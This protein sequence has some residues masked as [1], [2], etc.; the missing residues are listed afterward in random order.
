MKPSKSITS[1]SSIPMMNAPRECP[2]IVTLVALCEAMVVRTA[3]R[4]TVAVLEIPFF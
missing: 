2:T 3:E 1:K 4:I